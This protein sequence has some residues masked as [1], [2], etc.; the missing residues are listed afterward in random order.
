MQAKIL[1][2]EEMK[3]SYQTQIGKVQDELLDTQRELVE[4][5]AMLGDQ[6]LGA[7]GAD[8]WRRNLCAGRQVE[9]L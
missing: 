4:R 9:Q 2:P 5:K 6:G 1:F 8:Q 7:S 3:K